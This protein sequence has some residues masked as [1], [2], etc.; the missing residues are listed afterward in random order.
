MNE[1]SDL[2]YRKDANLVF[3]KRFG[4]VHKIDNMGKLF[5]ELLLTGN[6]TTTASCILSQQFQA[7]S[8]IIEKDMNIFLKILLSDVAG[9][10]T[11]INNE[12]HKLTP[13]DLSFPLSIEI[14]LTKA[15]NLACRFCYNIWKNSGAN[16]A[17]NR[18]VNLGIME[19]KKIQSESAQHGLFK[20]RYS[21]GEP[22]LHPDFKKIIQNGASL[23]LY[24][25]VFTNGYFLSSDMAK[26]FK[27]NLVKEV[28]ISLHG[29]KEFHESITTKTG[30]FEKALSA[31]RIAL[32][33][34]LQV[35]AE[36]VVTNNN[37]DKIN[38]VINTLTEIGVKDLR[39]MRYVKTG[40]NDNNFNLSP[41]SFATVLDSI[42]KT[43]INIGAPCS[44]IHC[45]DSNKQPI[46]TID[47]HRQRL[48]YLYSHCNAGIN[49]MAIAY[50]GDFKIC[51]HSKTFYGNTYDDV[52]IAQAWEMI[53]SAAKNS[54]ILN[55][56]PGCQLCVL[57]PKCLGGCHLNA[58]DI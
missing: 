54:I 9:N 29:D 6:D 16:L 27:R 56:P 36:M 33:E 18:N 10:S 52:K 41:E 50:N 28:L 42:E 1:L 23:G 46:I 3:N 15:C 11:D 55:T 17:S 47:A 30:S 12:L 53:K 22:L 14:E 13:S 32:E 49:W 26:F 44:Q 34:G 48:N 25:V 31:M 20:I 38:A 5:L 35:I 24:Q 58:G 8:K 21:G 45:L 7:S 39:L 2:V 37:K 19:I 51:P 40:V 4:C 57:Y 43:S